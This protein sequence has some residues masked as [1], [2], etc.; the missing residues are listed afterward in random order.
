MS[1]ATSDLNSIPLRAEFVTTRWSVVLAAGH[2]NSPCNPCSRFGGAGQTFP[3]GEKVE[4]R[5]VTFTNRYGMS[6]LMAT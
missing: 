4:H 3:K 2:F 5:K 6:A 1:G